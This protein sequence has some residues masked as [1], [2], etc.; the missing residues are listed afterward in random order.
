MRQPIMRTAAIISACLGLFCGWLAWRVPE[1][2][3]P[4]WVQVQ[5]QLDVSYIT[6][7]KKG[8]SLSAHAAIL[9]ENTTGT[10][11]YALNEHAARA[12]ASLTK[13]MT[14][15][16]AIEHGRLDDIVKVSRQAAGVSGS[17][18][19]LHT[20]QE[21][22]MEDLLY[23]ML[24]RSGNDAAVAVAEHLASSVSDFAGLMN[25]RAKEL[26]AVNTR[27][28]NPHGLDKPGHYSS[29]FDLAMISRVALLYPKFAQI[30]GTSRYLYEEQGV[31]W[32][33]TN[34]LLWS[35][36][37]SEGIKT[38][39]TGQAG[40]CLVAAAERAGMELIAVVLGSGNRWGDAIRML[41]YGF[42]KFTV[43][44]VAEKGVT[45][46]EMKLAYSNRTLGL[47]AAG[48]LSTIVRANSDGPVSTRV[49][50]NEIKL[51]IASQQRLG[52]YEVYV[53]GAKVADIP[54]LAQQRVP[55]PSLLERLFYWIIGS[56][57]IPA[58]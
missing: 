38:G 13:I 18:A 25:A 10:V 33:N 48:D 14:A 20:G 2:A 28:V 53:S 24:L 36:A 42:N 26:G 5:P 37:G 16:L 11:L 17:S 51:P 58:A 30:V 6:D 32:Q 34:R 29:A 39:T 56:R 7:A 49:V 43:L 22:R 4:V 8:L 54:L 31:T 46:A 35:Y 45:L 19:H 21:I 50:L 27:F 52:T 44:K 41:D 40:P 23:G 55:A 15:L 12:P 1:P 57:Q 47:A 9:F 3:T